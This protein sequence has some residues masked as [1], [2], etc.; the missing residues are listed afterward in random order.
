MNPQA[1]H[2]LLC[3]VASAVGSAM[4]E[5]G[6]SAELQNR[7]LHNLDQVYLVVMSSFQQEQHQQVQ[8]KQVVN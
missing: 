3:I 5:G 2:D 7:V 8:K 6:A 4:R 1:V